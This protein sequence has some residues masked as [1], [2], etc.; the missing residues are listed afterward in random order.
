MVLTHSRCDLFHDLL[1]RP[2]GSFGMKSQLLEAE[3]GIEP[4]H[5]AFADPLRPVISVRNVNDH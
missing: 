1:P 3:I 4:M 5:T 2:R